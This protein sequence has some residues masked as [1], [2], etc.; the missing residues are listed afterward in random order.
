VFDAHKVPTRSDAT[1]RRESG[2]P[3]LV[4]V[5]HKVGFRSA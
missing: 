5:T 3:E 1:R 2:G 4:L